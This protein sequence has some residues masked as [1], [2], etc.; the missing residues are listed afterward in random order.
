MRFSSLSRVDDIEEQGTLD[1]GNLGRFCFVS[2]WTNEVEE[3]IP[4]WNL[5]TP[6]MTGV[7][8]RLPVDP[9]KIVKINPDGRNIT[10][11]YLTHP[12]LINEELA[13]HGYSLNP[14]FMAKIHPIEY[15]SELNKLNKEVLTE[16][17]RETKTEN[18]IKKISEEKNIDIKSIGI[19]K[20]ENWKFQKEFRYRFFIVPWTIN[21]LE[22]AKSHEDN[23]RLIDRL[24]T[25]KLRK[26]FFDLELDE[27][28][29]K[30]MKILIGPR[31]NYAQKQIIWSLVND[32][33]PHANISE[34]K[35]KI[36][37]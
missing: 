23:E 15:T 35:L 14:P 31:A 13:P 19:Y 12:L 26:D 25:D 37:K 30:D 1:F 9:F 32:L 11:E 5:Y 6:D 20:N 7:R 3:S 2:C 21:D 4:L 16:I 27:K 24:K 17:K 29:I 10:E 28:A 8:I 18:G 33:N 36:K 22:K 34:S